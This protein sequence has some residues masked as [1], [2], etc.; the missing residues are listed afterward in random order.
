MRRGVLAGA[1]AAALCALCLGLS[2]AARGGSTDPQWGWWVGNSQGFFFSLEADGLH[3][4]DFHSIGMCGAEP[5]ADIEETLTPAIVAPDGSGNFAGSG[6]DQY[7]Q[8]YAFRGHLGQTHA[9]GTFRIVSAPSFCQ[10]G[11]RGDSGVIT[12]DATCFLY[13]PA[14][15]PAPTRRRPGTGRWP[16]RQPSSA[17]ASAVA[18]ITTTGPPSYG[19]R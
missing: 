11:S 17:A 3:D 10:D 14:A 19:R 8:E 7:G 5:S 15:R 9:T 18:R 16:T 1:A 13:C 6:T 12:F 4:V 2:S